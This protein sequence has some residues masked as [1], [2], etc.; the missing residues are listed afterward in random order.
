M[1]RNYT[2]TRK[3]CNLCNV[4]YLS[5]LYPAAQVFFKVNSLPTVLNPL[6]C[7]LR[8]RSSGMR[9]LVD[10]KL[11]VN[12]CSK[13]SYNLSYRTL[14]ELLYSG[15]LLSSHFLTLCTYLRLAGQN[16]I[17]FTK[18]VKPTYSTKD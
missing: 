17:Y 9:L 18:A 10:F 8:E 2:F 4:T 16:R 5:F 11:D 15:A 1:T 3:S 6:S 14:F 7:S 12:P 13:R